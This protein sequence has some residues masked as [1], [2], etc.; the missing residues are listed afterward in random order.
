MRTI[1]PAIKVGITFIIML[2]VAYWAFNMLIKGSW[3]DADEGQILVHAYFRDATSLVEKSR[4]QV[5]GINVGNI[6]SRELNVLPPRPE[7]IQA[8]RFAKV[9]VALRPGIKLYSNAVIK[10]TTASMLGEF[11]L[12]VDPGTYEWRDAAGVVHT[13]E[14]L[15]T[16]AEILFVGEA[17]T[18]GTMMEKMSTMVPLIQGLLKDLSKFTRGPLTSMAK[19][20]NEGIAENRKSVKTLLINLEAVSGDIRKVTRGADVDVKAILRDIRNITGNVRTALASADIGQYGNKV[21]TGLD[22]INSSVTK[23]DKAMG[24]VVGISEDTKQITAGMAAGKGTIGRLL[25]DDTLIKNLEGTVE[26]AGD[27]IESTLGLQTVVGL[28][29]EYNFQAGSIKT[30]LSVELK[31]RP[32]K[33]YIIELIDDPRGKRNV[34][35]TLTRSDD[36]SK[37]LLTREEKIELSDQ[38]R[39]TFQFA[40]RIK[41]AT[42]RFGIKE[43]TGGIGVDLNFWKDR[44]NIQT[45]VFDFSSNV[46]PRLKVLAAW[47]FFHRLYVVGGVDDILN[48][49]PEDGTGGGRDF[50]V[51]AQLRFN[52]EDLKALMLFGGSALGGLGGK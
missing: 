46:Y 27:F 7:Q 1:G 22:K 8:K 6:V 30:Y 36:P 48:E 29:S 17:T 12:E 34:T 26:K 4:V 49:R 31:P 25:T 10:K 15:K 20:L 50:F 3:G 32:D 42:F 33:Y 21:N 2:G 39:I 43:S 37:P 11:Y 44:I 13:D 5:A 19:N 38:F 14:Q 40:K 41:F 24:N 18:M 23:L 35:T 9:T 28:R 16:G 52:D 45:D 51:G 47:E